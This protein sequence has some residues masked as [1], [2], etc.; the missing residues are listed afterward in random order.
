MRAVIYG[1][2]SLGT[3]LGAFITKAGGSIELVNRNAAHVKALQEDGAKVVGTVEFTQKMTLQ[4]GEYLLSMSCT[5]F[6]HGEH[7]VYHRLYDVIS[8]TVISNKNTVGGYDMESTVKAE[9]TPAEEK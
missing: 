8:L 4:G 7:V 1:A 5:G 9:L 3:I 2:G 6:E